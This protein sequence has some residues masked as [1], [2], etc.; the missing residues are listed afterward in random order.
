MTITVLY[1]ASLRDAAG[2]SSE[3]LPLPASLPA[4]YES[5]RARHRFTLPVGQLRVAV[6]G[7]F[8]PWSTPLRDGCEVAF[9]PPVSGG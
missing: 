1:F 8:V 7:A 2:V 6:D 4:L 5:L 9:I 3:T